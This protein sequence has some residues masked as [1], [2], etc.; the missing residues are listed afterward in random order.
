[1]NRPQTYAKVFQLKSEHAAQ[2]AEY[3]KLLDLRAA[4]VQKLEAQLREAAYGGTMG[5]AATNVNNAIA[6]K[7][8]MVHTAAGQAL[9]EIHVQVSRFESRFVFSAIYRL[10]QGRETDS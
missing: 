8:T 6:G 1:M 9:F 5:R 7:E 3:K 10:F 2:T 4:R